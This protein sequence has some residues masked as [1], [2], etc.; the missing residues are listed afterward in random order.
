MTALT[1]D[2][3]GTTWL[4]ASDGLY[5]LNDGG[6]DPF[7]N[8]GDD[9]WTNYT[10]YT[11]ELID[12]YIRTLAAD[13]AG[14]LWIGTGAGLSLL[15]SGERWRNY[16]PLDGLG[17]GVINAIAVDA[18][19]HRW[20]ATGPDFNFYQNEPVTLPG[21]VTVAIGPGLPEAPWKTFVYDDNSP[22]NSLGSNQIAA[23]AT[24]PAGNLWIVGSQPV[25]QQSVPWKSPG[26]ASPL[27]QGYSP[28]VQ[29]LAP[30][31]NWTDFWPP[32]SYYR[33]IPDMVVDA[34]GQ[35][36]IAVD[37]GGDTGDLYV[38]SPHQNRWETR[39]PAG[40]PGQPKAMAIAGTT[41]WV[42]FDRLQAADF[43]PEG[44][45]TYSLIDQ[46]WTM[47][48]R[49][50]EDPAV[51][52]LEFRDLAIDAAGDVWV[53]TD[54]GVRRLS[55][56][57]VTWST[58]ENDPNQPDT[59]VSND[60]WAIAID[61]QGN[62]WF[63]TP[64]GASVLSADGSQ[65]ATFSANATILAID[66]Q[67]DIWFGNRHAPGGRRLDYGASPFDQLEDELTVYD[68]LPDLGN[69][70]VNDI[71]VDEAGQVWFAT[72]G[73]GLARYAPSFSSAGRVLWQHTAVLNANSPETVPEVANLTAAELGVTGKLYL[74]ADLATTLGQPL[75][76]ARYPFY[77]FPTQTGL[78][79]A[80]DRPVYQPNQPLTLS[81]QIRNGAALPLSHQTLTVS[82]N[83]QMVYSETNITIPAK[84]EYPFSVNTPA[85]ASVGRVI[86]GAALDDLTV[87]D[88]ILVATPALDA[89]LSAPELVGHTP[90]DLRL[91]LTNLGRL[92][93]ALTATL[94]GQAESLTLPAGETRIIT[95]MKQIVA[96]TIVTAQISGDVTAEVTRPI[97]MGEAAAMAFSSQ[98]LY[99][100]GRVEIPY[101]ITNTGQLPLAFPLELALYSGPTLV[102]S[103]HLDV[104]LPVNR[105]LSGWLA[106]NLPPGD[107]RLDYALP[108]TSS[109]FSLQP[110]AFRVAALDQVSLQ[111][112]AQTPVG[113]EI[114]LTVTVTNTGANAIS[115]DIEVETDFFSGNFDFNFEGTELLPGLTVT[116]AVS[117]DT[118]HAAP[119]SH[120]VT[121][122]VVAANG[123]VLA[124]Q[125]ITV[126]VSPPHLTLVSSPP[127][128]LSLSPGQVVT[129]TFAVENS[130]GSP[131]GALLHVSLADFEDE[132][133]LLPLEPGESGSLDF[134]FYLPP[135][136]ATGDYVVAY[137]LSEPTT[138]QIQR[139][140]LTLN[141]AGM[142]LAVTAAL[143][144]A[145]YTPGETAGLTLNISNQSAWPT[146][147]L[148]ALA[149]FGGAVVTQT[150][151]LAGYGAQTLNLAVP[152]AA[153]EVGDTLFYGIYD[154]ASVN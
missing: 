110:S 55:A 93:L 1:I 76:S 108:F 38:L 153:A 134:S 9:S 58:Y 89:Y 125:V 122:T 27:R 101:L 96:D 6:T 39:R 52:H 79:L 73:R 35:V 103:D 120:P 17:S 116:P 47:V 95:G 11:G 12:N 118:T 145:V 65:W 92:D 66:N 132:S 7:V 45:A 94:D 151:N 50:S 83:G 18:D 74:E 131:G 25:P 29:R 67:G 111:V 84:A 138:G 70:Y 80:A 56:D 69:K 146:P 21:G 37:D 77:V 130:G 16:T 36:W 53:A 46:T 3:A 72:S 62:H 63:A 2:P 142:D 42:A 71:A 28:L 106:F 10:A 59:L 54:Q 4:G 102:R 133:Q 26:L 34:A 57:G 144:K 152:I 99:A 33:H 31:H 23:V 60:V 98:P 68:G 129:L 22:N 20:L 147:N 13:R 127:S 5:R 87:Q 124:T 40:L 128:S 43:H 143:D 115:G 82:V 140:D 112:Q 44:I 105:T 48:Y 114:P 107:Y 139:G 154:Q 148:Y 100:A 24:D 135:E 119:G 90:F 19:G 81:G 88:N 137:V 49:G 75:G 32:F 150:F 15:L 104:A 30:G 51:D 8:T 78:T 85:P 121:V 136:L 91:T 86:V 14:N 149:R 117:V 61:P 141:V 64:D 123:A 126:T 113:A 41:V 109:A 97:T